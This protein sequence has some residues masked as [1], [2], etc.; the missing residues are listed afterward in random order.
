MDP[1]LAAARTLATESIA[2]IYSSTALRARQTA[3][4]LAAPGIP[5]SALPALAEM[6]IGEQEGTND[7]AVRA[8]TAE[9]LHAWIVHQDLAQRVAD[10]E[11]GHQVVTRMTTALQ[12]ITAAHPDE[13]VALVGHVASLTITLSR[14][15]G[16]GA[17]V[18][19]TPLP[20]AHP[21]LT[22]WDGTTWQCPTWP[23]PTV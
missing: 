7:P 3:Q 15:C 4:L 17:E 8:R 16:L 5:V 6:G 12:R 13:T 1:G 19:G 18:W 20:H 11:T 14:L 21:F 22:E 10:G 9:V 2:H 23:R